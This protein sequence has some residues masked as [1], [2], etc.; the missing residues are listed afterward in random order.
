VSGKGALLIPPFDSHIFSYRTSV[1]ASVSAVRIT[2]YVLPDVKVMPICSSSSL[3]FLLHWFSWAVNMTHHLLKNKSSISMGY[4]S[5]FS[6][7]SRALSHMFCN[8]TKKVHDS[9]KHWF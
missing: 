9:L 1:A 3:Q 2:A 4:S 7:E 5:V 6:I 8:S